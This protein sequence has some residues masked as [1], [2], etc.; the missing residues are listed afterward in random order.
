MKNVIFVFIISLCMICSPEQTAQIP[1]FAKI[2]EKKQPVSL[3]KDP[4]VPYSKRKHN[5]KFS[6][7]LNAVKTQSVKVIP[8]I[9]N[10]DQNHEER[11]LCLALNIYHE[12]RGSSTSDQKAVAYVSLN[13]VRQD[14]F[15]DAV[16]DVVWQQARIK[17]GKIVGQF[18]WTVD[19][20]NKIL[21]KEKE[22]WEKSQEIAYKVYK[23]NYS[24]NYEKHDITD[25]A[26]HYYAP[27]L[28]NA[29]KWAKGH[30]VK[31]TK[32]IGQHVYIVMK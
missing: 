26:T 28:I 5:A 29:P 20:A 24:D 6:N 1:T 7:F 10:A 9:A 27:K 16:C 2:P 15:P 4:T 22:A 32:K 25:G 19:S 14:N 18:S 11:M 17:S 3:V 12:A 31:F 8:E 13:R 21:P 30:N 23:Q